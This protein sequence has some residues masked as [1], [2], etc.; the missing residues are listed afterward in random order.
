MSTSTTD[1]TRMSAWDILRRGISL[2]PALRE[3]IG[4][5]LLLA[6][7]STV[8]TSVVPIVIQV[9]IDKGFDDDVNRS[10]VWWYVAGAAVIVV[11]TAVCAYATKVRLFI[12]S[13]RGLAQ[14]RVYA[15]RH[16]HDLSM[17]TQ[18]SERRGSLVSR[19]TSDIDQVSLFVQFTGMMIVV[20]VGQM[21][22]ATVIM[23]W[24]S[25]QLTIVV[26]V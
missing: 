3:G 17:L 2:S 11:I 18:N 26:W 15:F 5:T 10:Q 16:V 23:A 14:L 7:L 20:S 21:L 25:W 1:E 4:V 8:G 12:A 24:Y 22:V 6:A 9:M 19:V 13:E